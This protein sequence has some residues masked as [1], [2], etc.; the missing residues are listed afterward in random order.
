MAKNASAVS[1]E[2]GKD[3]AGNVDD[4]AGLTSVKQPHDPRAGQDSLADAVLVGADG[5]HESVADLAVDLDH[6]LELFRGTQSLVELWPAL[7]VHRVFVPRRAPQLLGQVRRQ[8][9]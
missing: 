1:E 5:K 6:Q 3:L 2:D 4:L 9:G 8:I 7:Q